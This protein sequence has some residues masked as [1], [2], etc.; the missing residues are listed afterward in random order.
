M[1]MGISEC[2]KISNNLEI[3]KQKQQRNS[4]K[5]EM[6]RPEDINN[7]HLSMTTDPVEKKARRGIFSNI[8]EIESKY[9][10]P[11][12]KYSAEKMIDELLNLIKNG[13]EEKVMFGV[14]NGLVYGIE[15][16]KETI[17]KINKGSIIDWLIKKADLLNQRQ[18]NLSTNNN[19]KPLLQEISNLILTGTPIS[20]EILTSHS[21]FISQLEAQKDRIAYL[22]NLEEIVCKSIENVGKEGVVVQRDSQFYCVKCP[23]DSII[24]PTKFMDAP[25][26]KDLEYG[27][28]QIGEGQ[29]IIRLLNGKYHDMKGRVKMTFEINDEVLEMTLSSEKA[30]EYEL[31][32]MYFGCIVVEMDDKNCEIFSRYC[33]ELGKEP[34]LEKVLWCAE[35]FVKQKKNEPT[36]RLAG[37]RK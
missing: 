22:S 29:N 28:L 1:N 10:M 23:E 6:K 2:V 32:A 37:L 24:M 19:L 14:P 9:R 11:L 4:Y 7:F 3:K 12:N 8:L 35:N 25:E 5:E 30:D 21:Y 26:F 16:D 20:A 15:P 31:N 17:E 33:D 13:Q 34:R 36:D 18:D 27:A